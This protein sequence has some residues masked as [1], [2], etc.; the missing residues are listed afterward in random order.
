MK[1][2]NNQN[3]IA[4]ARRH[5]KSFTAAIDAQCYHCRGGG[6]EDIVSNRQILKDIFECDA[7][8]CELKRHRKVSGAKRAYQVKE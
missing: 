4:R 6:I 8:Y 3:P 2:T 1:H 7:M 5:P